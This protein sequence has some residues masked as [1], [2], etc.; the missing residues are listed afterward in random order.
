MTTTASPANSL[1]RRFL[2]LAS[3]SPVLGVA[4]L[5]GRK[6]AVTLPA[7]AAAAPAAPAEDEASRGYRETEH[8]RKFYR[9]ARY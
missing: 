7:A 3:W 9:S 4:M 8:I 1:R 6:P 2:R 5:A